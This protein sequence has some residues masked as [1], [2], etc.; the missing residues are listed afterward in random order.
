MSNFQVKKNKRNNIEGAR[1]FRSSE[2]K[3]LEHLRAFTFIQSKTNRREIL[4][5]HNF[6]NK[7]KLQKGP[8]RVAD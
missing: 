8:F 1:H 4:V 2:Y 3:F 6:I 5:N 7:D